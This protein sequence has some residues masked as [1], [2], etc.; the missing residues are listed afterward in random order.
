MR[1]FS[2]LFVVLGA[3]FAFNK[4]VIIHPKIAK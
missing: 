3:E 1:Y 2:M 4:T